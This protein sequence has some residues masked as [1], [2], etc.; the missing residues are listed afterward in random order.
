MPLLPPR[1][2][3][4]LLLLLLLSLPIAAGLAW[5]LLTGAFDRVHGLL[6]VKPPDLRNWRFLWEAIGGRPP[7]IVPLVN[8]LIFASVVAAV[9]VGGLPRAAH[10]LPPHLLPRPHIYL[11]VLLALAALSPATLIFSFLFFLALL[12][13][14]R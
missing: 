4:V 8:S 13:V 10:A 2:R 11:G 6:P 1:W 12:G 5:L 7:A 9:W 14:L 3:L